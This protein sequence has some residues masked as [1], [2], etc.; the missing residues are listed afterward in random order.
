MAWQTELNAVEFE[1][2]KHM[3]D[4]P[5]YSATL[6]NP[7]LER[8]RAGGVALGMNIRLAHSGE[9]ASIARTTGHDFLFLDA[10]HATFS[11]ETLAHI[12][13]AA[14]GCGVAPFVRVRGCEDPD[15]SLLLDS[16]ITGI[17]VP[18]VNTA[19][20]ARKAVQAARFPPFGRRSASGGY[21]RFDFR[22]VPLGEA[23]EALNRATLVACMIESREGLNNIEEI[24]GVD[25][26]DVIHV[27]CNDLLLD[28]GKPGAFGD[29]EVVRA[30]DHVIDVTVAK[31]KFAGFGGDRDLA[32]QARFIRQ[33]V[34]FM[35]THSDIG[36]LMAEASRRT[37]ELRHAIRRDNG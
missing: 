32:R 23:M 31:G 14:R 1:R 10:Q 12:A 16:G 17:I 7:V 8:M 5:E 26:I 36:F 24:C 29:P 18:D 35:T 3:P 6:V 28:M 15:I 33:G 2:S 22:P 20:Q 37:A 34:K 9:I 4:A 19:A 11:N 30:I 25:G 13:L 27:G 21:S